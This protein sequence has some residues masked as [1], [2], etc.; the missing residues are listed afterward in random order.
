MKVI[1]NSRF[2]EVTEGEPV[3]VRVGAPP[4]KGKANLAFVKILSKHYGCRVK[5]VS[6]HS[7]RKKIVELEE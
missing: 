1:P 6:G 7:S 2:E 3:V 4:E 5:I